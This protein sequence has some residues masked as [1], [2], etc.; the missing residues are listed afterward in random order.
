M[1]RAFRQWWHGSDGTAAIEFAIV[2]GLFFMIILGLI[3]LATNFYRLHYVSFIADQAIRKIYINPSISSADLQTWI[4]SVSDGRVTAT[5]QASTRATAM[6]EKDLVL[7]TP[8]QFVFLPVP[9]SL[10]IS[11]SRTVPIVGPYF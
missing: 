1:K 3:D 11:V 9:V 2:G 8:S 5:L 10:D 6:P 4:T 7:V